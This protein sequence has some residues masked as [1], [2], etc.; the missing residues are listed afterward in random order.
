[1]WPV[2][3]IA[4]FVQANSDITLVLLSVRIPILV[5]V[6]AWGIIIVFVVLVPSLYRFL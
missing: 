4:V 6:V 2:L 3:V 1:M 5:T